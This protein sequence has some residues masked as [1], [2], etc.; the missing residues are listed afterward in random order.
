MYALS[1]FGMSPP[2]CIPGVLLLWAVGALAAEP[3]VTA[4]IVGGTVSSFE[5]R[6]EGRLQL[7]A[8][9]VFLFHSKG[10][11]LRIP[12]NRIHTLEYGQRVNRRYAESVLI[13]PVFLL[14][15]SRKH[16]VTIGYVDDA[17]HQ[18]ALVFEVG[19]HDIR[20]VLAGL[21]AKT[22]RKV[23]YQDEEARKSGKG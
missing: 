16:F 11:G 19:K 4:H 17:G 23:E 3:G 13:S 22:G 5:N 21:E 2:R 1:H 14:S 12:Y 8:P 9:D 20:P 15:K 7:T 10:A 6:S 18:Q